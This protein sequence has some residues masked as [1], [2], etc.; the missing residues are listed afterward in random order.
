MMNNNKR[1][2]CGRRKRERK[3][4]WAE[5]E[6]ETPTNKKKIEFEKSE[7]HLL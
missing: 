2:R 3:N 7:G 4:A 1:T 6:K 5:R